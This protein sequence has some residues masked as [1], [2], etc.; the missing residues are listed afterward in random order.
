MSTRSS[1]HAGVYDVQVTDPGAVVVDCRAFEKSLKYTQKF[2]GALQTQQPEAIDEL[3]EG[4]GALEF[5]RETDDGDVKRL[6]LQ[7]YEIVALTNLNPSTA[8]AAKS[9]IPSL[10][11]LTDEELES[12]VLKLLRRSSA[13]YTGLEQ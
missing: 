13:R 6:K 11:K 4:L 2:G 5:L 8:A 10:E 12:E 1:T 3:F 7:S 9:L